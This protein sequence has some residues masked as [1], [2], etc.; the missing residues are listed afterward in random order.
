MDKMAKKMEFERVLDRTIV[1]V[2]MDAYYAAVEMRDDPTLRYN[3]WPGRLVAIKKRMRKIF[4]LSFI[5]QRAHGSGW[6]LDAVY[7]ELFG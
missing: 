1:H 2:D 4:N 7:I 5:Q 3:I 6:R